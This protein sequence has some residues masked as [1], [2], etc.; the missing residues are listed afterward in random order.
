[1][2]KVKK[3]NEFEDLDKWQRLTDE[4]INHPFIYD[5]FQTTDI[6]KKEQ[7]LLLMLEQLDSDFKK[8]QRIMLM[9]DSVDIDELREFM[10]QTILR[11]D[12]FSYASRWIQL[13]HKK[14]E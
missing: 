2:S 5:Y 14:E 7:C 9:P 4:K 8:M 11:I 12:G 10:R 3:N 6:K 13:T 1:M